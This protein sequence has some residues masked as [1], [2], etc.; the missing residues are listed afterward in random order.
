MIL[1]NPE[2]GAPIKNF[3]FEGITYF[4][5]KDNQVFKPG[6]IVRIDD[7]RAAAYI[8]ETYG[9]LEEKTKIEAKNILD[10]KASYTFACDK[11]DYKTDTNDKLKGHSIHHAR[12]AKLDD[13]LGIPVITGFKKEG[14]ASDESVDRQRI[15]DAEGGRDGLIGEGLV[16]E[17][18]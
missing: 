13:E 11:C 12:E 7:E 18:I 14:Q 8:K 3:P 15:I 1:Y 5:E 16:E 9:F 17:R 10:K 6:D 2:N 4:L